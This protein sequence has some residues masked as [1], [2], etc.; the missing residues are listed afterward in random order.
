M[1]FL[2]L[3]HYHT[4]EGQSTLTFIHIEWSIAFF[5]NRIYPAYS[6]PSGVVLAKTA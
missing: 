3:F 1:H 4:L 6:A 2:F 5:T